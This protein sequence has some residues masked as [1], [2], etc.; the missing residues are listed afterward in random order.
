VPNGCITVPA[1]SGCCDPSGY[2]R[3]FRE[4]DAK[5]AVRSFEK[6][7]LDATA[8][9]MVRALTER[10]L[11]GKTLLE[12][13]AGAGLAQVALLEAG[14]ATS[15]AYDIS[16]G[17]VDVAQ[18]LLHG[19]GLEDR[20][21]WHTGDY[22]DAT[23]QG[24]ADVVFLNRVVCCYPDMPSLV[25]RVAGHSKSYLAMAYPRNRLLSRIALRLANAFL[26]IRRVPF[27]VYVHD[28]DEIQR[29]VGTAGLEPV[30]SGD[31]RVWHWQVW[32]RPAA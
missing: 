7:G 9:P 32:E 29:R 30:A 4:K 2:R 20:V 31:T 24:P 21:T 25:D 1:V 13:G 28:T 3:V 6:K 15:V 23:D 26:W 5:R 19:R 14:V 8:G 22:L 10:G 12:V 18:A 17:Y 27:R 16:A 11:E